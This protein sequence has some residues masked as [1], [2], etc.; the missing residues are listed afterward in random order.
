VSVRE[1]ND[2]TREGAAVMRD[3]LEC[4]CPRSLRHRRLTLL[5]Y[6]GLKPVDDAAGGEYEYCLPLHRVYTKSKQE[7]RD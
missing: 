5:K 2:E 7:T 4:T 3:R 6:V 1:R